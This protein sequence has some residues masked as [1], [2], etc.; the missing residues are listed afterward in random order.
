MKSSLRC[1][2]P[3]GAVLIL[4]SAALPL[5][6]QAAKS[7]DG[8]LFL[9]IVTTVPGPDAP[10]PGAPAWLTYIN[11]Y[12]AGSNL[13][14]LAEDASLSA[15]ASLHAKYS[16]INNVLDHTEDPSKPGYTPEGSAAASASNVMGTSYAPTTDQAAIDMWME[17]P[18]HA[19]G[20]LD[21]HLTITGF[22]SFRDAAAAGTIRM[23]AALDVLSKRSGTLPPGAT[24]PVMWPGNGATVALTAYPGNEYP[25][26]L[27]SCSGY[28]TPTGLPVI[29]QVGDGSQTPHVT[30]HSFA[31]GATL[32]E[33]CVYDET[34]FTGAAVGT[35]ILDFRDAIV[36]I[37]RA[38]LVHGQTYTV[39][40]TDRETAYSW[41]FTIDH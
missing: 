4:L 27:A 19:L 37:P 31:Q 9:P 1:I 25:D 10:T 6:V 41:S 7:W 39:S 35:S 5:P 36:L 13:P 34:T 16:V 15:G 11:A 26:P 32:L 12:R 14:L 2:A 23:A 20:M 21:P 40:I 28:K 18:F 29:L 38:P 30:A 3:L 24:Y 33:S 22:G 8:R 17:G